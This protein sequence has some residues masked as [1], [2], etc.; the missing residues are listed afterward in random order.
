MC[1]M[2][3]W[4]KMFPPLCVNCIHIKSSKSS[5]QQKKWT[6]APPVIDMP[7]LVLECERSLNESHRLLGQTKTENIPA[8]QRSTLPLTQRAC[9]DQADKPS[10]AAAGPRPVGPHLKRMTS[11][12][13][14]P[15][16]YAMW[17][18]VDKCMFIVTCA[19]FLPVPTFSLHSEGFKLQ[20]FEAQIQVKT[21]HCFTNV[22]PSP[23]SLPPFSLFV[24]CTGH[25]AS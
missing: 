2:W 6:C 8:M 13:T 1:W 21:L 20:T 3:C 12:Y 11:V 23:P 18:S 16:M 17:G 24:S 10:P 5:E 22:P 15:G 9:W 25:W 7:Q 14:C 19:Y 4:C